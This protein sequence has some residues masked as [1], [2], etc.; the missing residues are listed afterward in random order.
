MRFFDKS[1][2]A[3]DLSSADFLFIIS[4]YG[5]NLS[6]ILHMVPLIPAAIMAQHYYNYYYGSVFNLSVNGWWL[7]QRTV[8]LVFLFAM[9]MLVFAMHKK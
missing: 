7:C 3:S 8:P 5:S 9:S 2:K 1:S 6:I 4:T